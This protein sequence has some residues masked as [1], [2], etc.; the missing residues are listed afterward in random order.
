MIFISSFISRLCSESSR[1]WPNCSYRPWLSPTKSLGRPSWL[2]LS[3]FIVIQCFAQSASSF[4]STYRNHLNLSFLITKLIGSSHRRYGKINCP[5]PHPVPIDFPFLAQPI[6]ISS[7]SAQKYFV[8]FVPTVHIIILPYFT[9]LVKWCCM[10]A[11]LARL[12]L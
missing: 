4:C 6:K 2:V 10:T 3:T 1:D 12:K 5:H 9:I 7:A 8:Y 11:Q